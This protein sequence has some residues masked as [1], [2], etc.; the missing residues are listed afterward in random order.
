MAA[1]A[2]ESVDP[3]LLRSAFRSFTTTVGLITTLG[4]RGPNVMSAEW[5]FNVSYDPFLIAVCVR[6]VDV[7][8]AAIADTGEFGVNLPS[9]DQVDLIGF[10]GNFSKHQTDKL[11]STRFETYPSTKIRAPLIKGCLMNA[12]CRLVHRIELGDHTTFVGEVVAL[13]VDPSKGPLVYH[14]RAPRTAGPRISR[15]AAILVA[16]T[17]NANGPN[18]SIRVDGL[19]SRPDE[20]ASRIEVQVW[21]GENRPVAGAIARADSDGEFRLMLPFPET[22]PP[23]EYL[24]VARTGDTEGRA[25]FSVPALA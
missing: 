25:H 24:L 11:S 3:A 9:D 8:H 12:E 5:T 1:V 2:S 22:S 17:L 7:T 14:Q 18:R 23:G 13:S 4:R 10:A 20:T 16:A 6:P 19:L 15:R 21:D